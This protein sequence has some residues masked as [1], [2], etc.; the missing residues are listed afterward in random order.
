MTLKDKIEVFEKLGIFLEQFSGPDKNK[1]SMPWLEELNNR[2][3]RPLESIIQSIHIHNP[4]FTEDNV[5]F[6]LGSIG[7][8]LNTGDITSWLS[9][10]K[11]PDIQKDPKTIAVIMAG[12]IPLV[13]F[14]D[15]LC[16]LLSGHNLLAKLSVKDEQLPKITAEIICFLNSDFAGKIEF[17]ESRLKNFDAVIATG[18]GNTSRYFDYY[19]G[20]YPNIIRKNRNSAAILDGSETHE[21]L[22][23]LSD[24]V[25]LY[26][27]LGCRS[28][29]GLFVPQNYDFK[30]MLDSFSGYSHLID[31]NQWANNYEYQ[32]AVHLI[33]KIPHLDAG[34]LLIKEDKSLASPIAVLNYKVVDST[35]EALEMTDKEKDRLQCVVGNSK[36]PGKTVSFGKAQEPGVNEYADN[37]DTMEFLLNL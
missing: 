4:W 13:G 22:K 23:L 8:S 29:S 14:H 25:F 20:K 36:L 26:F 3:F 6:A 18:S 7:K 2:F 1:P 32:K 24:D 33:D 11:I 5:R 35:G 28:V 21:E 10:Y 37:V 19:F 15:M 12:N 31:H 34:F 9:C 27:G 30:N 16:V 17:K